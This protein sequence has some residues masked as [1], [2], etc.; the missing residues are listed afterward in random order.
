MLLSALPRVDDPISTYL[1]FAVD[2]PLFALSFASFSPSFALSAK[3]SALPPKLPLPD[4]PEPKLA[5]PDV[6]LD[7]PSVDASLPEA[8]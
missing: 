6:P 3:E 8:P 7:E 5:L 2:K 1:S 4:D